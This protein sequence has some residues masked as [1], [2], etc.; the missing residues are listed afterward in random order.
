VT[1][2]L[3]ADEFPAFFQAVHGVSPFPWQERLLRGIADRGSWP[4]VLDLPTG[5]GKTAALDVAVF[6]LAMDAHK[7]QERR[8]AVRI[9]FVVD[10]RLIVDDAYNRAKRI[11]TVLAEAARIESVPEIVRKVSLRLGSLAERKDRPLL[12][13]RL[14]GGVPREDDWARTP[15]QPTILCSTLDQVGSRLLFRGYGISDR[16]KPIHAGLLGSDCLILLDEAHLAEPFRQTIASITK[17]RRTDTATAPWHVALLSATSGVQVGMAFS[18]DDDDR[19]HRV[20]APRLIASKPAT[21]VEITGKQGVP[22]EIRRIEEIVNQV[23]RTLA[24]LRQ[25]L[26][27]PAIGVVVNRVMRARQIFEQLKAELSDTSVILIIGPARS[28]D[29]EELARRDLRPIRTGEQR[30]LQKPLVV[31]AT[32]TIEAGVDIDFDGLVTEA[33]ALDSLRQRF[34]RLN[35][36]GRDITPVATILAHKEDVAP[37]ADDPVYGDRIKRTWDKLNEIA[38]TSSEGVV[39]FGSAGFPRQLIE[40]SNDLGAEKTDAPILLPAYA[41]LWS[42]TSPIPNADPEVSLFLHGAGR[43]P[44]SVQIIWRADITEYDLG[45]RDRVAALLDLVPPRS[46]EAIEIPLWAARAWLQ[47]DTAAQPALSDM[48]ERAPEETRDR[49]GKRVFRYAG[50]DDERRTRVVVADELRNGDLIVVPAEY[51]GCD[52][53]GWAPNSTDPVVDLAEQASLPYATRRFAVRMTP[54]LVRQGLNHERLESSSESTTS[55][56]VARQD[57]CATLAEHRDEAP[58]S[59]LEAVLALQ[60]LPVRIRR[61]LEL[62]KHHKGLRLEP[63]FAYGYDSEDRPRGVVFLAPRGIKGTHLET[64]AEYEGGKPATEDDWLGSTPGYAQTLDE[65]S[66]QVRDRAAEFSRKAGLRPEVADDIA[67]AAYLHDAGKADLR[68]QTMLYGGDWF[69]VDDT[70]ILAKSA[71]RFSRAGWTKAGLPEKWRHEAL[72]VRI[73]REHVRIH[74]A[75]DPELVLWLIGVHHGYGRPLFPHADPSDE[76]DRNDLPNISGAVTTLKRGAGPQS[77]AFCFNGRDWPQ[78]FE[79]LKRRYGIWELARLEAI[80]RLADHRASEDAGHPR[81]DGGSS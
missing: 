25:D 28:A 46:G 55:I 73:A 39:E 13:R 26:S 24:V 12:A 53:W 70:R 11:E 23:R 56:D 21:L 76:H 77:L 81:A 6:H 75:N 47:G 5:S 57:L 67:L 48:A 37:R 1:D 38:A 8:A 22:A 51:G 27:N 15:S 7:P 68:F 17:M 30:E 78:I 29:R 66:C 61:D 10:R 62:L 79:H 2:A 18:L 4:S 59:L 43:S 19:T 80:V 33:A 34:G 41:D 50:S 64:A 49:L 16:M 65:H 9:A 60:P 40:N 31:V 14:R 52:Q 20:L 36:A 74:E 3:T 63:A 35:R 54:E 32:Q 45:D 42:Q 72:S 71:N 69:A 44:A 58:G